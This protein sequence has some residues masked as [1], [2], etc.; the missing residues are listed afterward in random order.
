MLRRE[1][2][3]EVNT[4][5]LDL[6]DQTMRRLLKN[7]DFTCNPRIMNHVFKA[8]Y[9][10][11]KSMGYHPDDSVAKHAW[12]H[13]RENQETLQR[14]RKNLMKM[15]DILGEHGYH[16]HIDGLLPIISEKEYTIASHF[17]RYISHVDKDDECAMCVQILHMCFGDIESERD[18]EKKS[19]IKRFCIH[20]VSTFYT[21]CPIEDLE[22]YFRRH[23]G[24]KFDAF[25]R[26]LYEKHK[27]FHPRILSLGAMDALGEENRYF[28][29]EW[30]LKDIIGFMDTSPHV[31]GGGGKKPKTRTNSRN[32]G[33]CPRT[34]RRRR[35]SR[36]GKRS[37]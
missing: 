5:M 29:Q 31:H 16:S 13:D 18:P 34:R 12:L 19:E 2:L 32:R 30:I 7:T 36:C 6:D 14:I 4:A 24:H 8:F 17:L 1:W 37:S 25:V 3:Q 22:Y 28:D 21:S 35:S 10:V 15:L 26:K 20:F 33:I 27:H 11:G 9:D 23:G